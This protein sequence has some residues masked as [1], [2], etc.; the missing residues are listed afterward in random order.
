MRLENARGLVVLV[1]EDPGTPEVMIFQRGGE[2]VLGAYK[3]QAWF[4]VPEGVEE[5]YIDI[6]LS[7][8]HRIRRFSIWDPDGEIAWELNYH[9]DYY[10][11]YDPLRIVINVEPGQAGRLWRL[12]LPFHHLRVWAQNP[13]FHETGGDRFVMDPQIPP[14]YSIDKERFFMPDYNL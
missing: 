6:P 12:A 7:R 11:G 3:N 13:A 10:D 8:G 9:G 4:Y 5:F 2:V 1:A 14:V